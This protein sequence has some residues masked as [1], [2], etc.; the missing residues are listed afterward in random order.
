MALIGDI[1]GKMYEIFR[2]GF[3]QLICGNCS[4]FIHI[5]ELFSLRAINLIPRRECESGRKV[6]GL[7]YKS[8]YPILSRTVLFM[9]SAVGTEEGASSP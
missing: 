9:H 5:S 6:L 4:I 8:P 7:G 1:A 3:S 2:C